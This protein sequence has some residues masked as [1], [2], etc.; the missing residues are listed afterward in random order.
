M[1]ETLVNIDIDVDTNHDGTYNVCLSAGNSTGTSYTNIS[2][3]C[4]GKC[5]ADMINEC[6]K[7]SSGK[8]YP[9]KNF[10][11]VRTDGYSM[12]STAYPDFESAADAMKKAYHELDNNIPGDDWYDMSYCSESE[13]LLYAGGEDVYLWNIIEI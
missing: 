7:L 1:P 13:A 8:S 10:M 5:V 11:L 6:E 12:E 3:D 4:I 2:A 9:I